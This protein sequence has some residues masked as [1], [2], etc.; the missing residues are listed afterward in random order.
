MAAGTRT[1]RW[2][3]NLR[4]DHQATIT[5]QTATITMQTSSPSNHHHEQG[6]YAY[7]PKPL[8]IKVFPNT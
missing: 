5:M 1:L 8:P 3:A 6:H 2:W 7:Y 4:A